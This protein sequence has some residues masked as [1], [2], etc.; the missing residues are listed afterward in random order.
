MRRALYYPHTELRERSNEGERLLKRA[1][2]L[3]DK[4]EFIVP[5]DDYRPHYTDR[6]FNEA[7]EIIGVRHVP[8]D[9]EKRVVHEQ[10]EELVT[11]P[12]LPAVFYYHGQQDPYE[13]YPQK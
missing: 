8:N 3:W 11:Q 13:I 10:V 7:M 2:L 4:L 6:R 1:L 5:D 12:V 9:E